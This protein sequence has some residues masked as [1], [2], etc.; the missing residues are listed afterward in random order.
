MKQQANLSVGGEEEKDLVP[1]RCY[2]TYY[3]SRE[4]M[5]FLMLPKRNG[6]GGGGGDFSEFRE[7]ERLI[8]ILYSQFTENERPSFSQ[9]Y[10]VMLKGEKH[11][12]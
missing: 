2:R 7:H 11:S 12:Y 1:N 8:G 6:K 9:S 3:P 10:A 4:V 5:T